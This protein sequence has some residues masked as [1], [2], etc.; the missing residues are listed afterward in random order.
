MALSSDL[1]SQFVKQTNDKPIEKKESKVYATVVKSDGRTYAKF[2]GSDLLTPINS[3]VDVNDGERVEIT[4]KNHTATIN[5]NI[6][7]PAARTD[8]V[9]EIGKKVAEFDTVIA[10]TVIAEVAKI[11]ALT[12]DS[13][14]IKKLEAD[15]AKIDDLEAETAKISELEAEIA[16]FDFVEAKDLEAANARI[17][18]LEATYVSATE[19]EAERAEID[20]VIANKLSA[21]SADIKYADIKLAKVDIADIKDF[22]ARS[23]ILGN[24]VVKDQ[25]ITGT[26]YGVTIKGDSIEGNTIKAD[27]LVVKGKDGLYYKLNVE[28][29]G[30]T[31]ASADEKYQNGI[32]G[33]VIIAK[34]I[35]AEEISVSDL[36]A[37][38]ATIGGFKIT[39]NSIH[40]L[41]KDSAGN[42]IRGIYLDNDGQMTIGDSD[43]YL[44]YYKDT[45]GAY[46]LAVAAKSIIFGSGS[47]NIEDVF[48]DVNDAIAETNDTINNIEIGGRNYISNSAFLNGSTGWSRDPGVTVDNT[49]LFNNHPTL[50]IEQSGF[51]ADEF[52]GATIGRLPNINS[53]SIKKSETITISFYYYLPTLDGFDSANLNMQFAGTK[54]G[55]SS[56][57][58]I[59]QFRC[60]KDSLVV[61][62]WTRVE[63]PITAANNYTKCYINTYINRNGL[64]WLA[65]FKLE[66]G[67]KATDW[68]PAPEDTLNDINNVV[69]SIEVGG[70]NYIANSAFIQGSDKWVL[71]P[72]CVV[73]TETL[74]DGNPTIKIYVTDKTSDVYIGAENDYTPTYRSFSLSTG[75]T[76]IFSFYYYI[77]SLDGFDSALYTEFKGI[78]E[79]STTDAA[80]LRKN[81]PLNELVVGAWTRFEM[82][83]PANTNYSNCYNNTFISRNGLIWLANFKLEKGTKTTAWT[84]APEDVDEGIQN[85]QNSGDKAQSGLEEANNR[86]NEAEL[87]IDAIEGQIVSTVTDE[88]GT[89]SLIQTGSNWTFNLGS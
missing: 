36:V 85:A 35:T 51:T 65:D 1:I 55:A 24:I 34:S 25:K 75:E 19:L 46:K 39:E 76:A 6:S 23:G 14:I 68:T 50:K 45:D 28:A 73:D 9:Q 78:K 69:N 77:P 86:L 80:I 89:T 64:I 12:A 26:L 21:E 62:Q 81:I 7:S 70:R 43:N 49:T 88:D 54:E 63:I 66:K 52:G 61:G 8:D 10:D 37:F 30:K 2:D 15:T 60:A 44:K 13:A 4:I 59:Y 53:F 79:G 48:A 18:N 74:Y 11:G 41:V 47:K 40:S 83:I 56:S 67:S 87:R 16:D 20:E 3:M 57:S 27:K 72:G 5:G 22:Y 82:I 71:D 33:S 32:D 58:A 38:D 29:L 42:T 84:P 17:N 31:T